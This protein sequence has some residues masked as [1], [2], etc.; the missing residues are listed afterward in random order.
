MSII[1]FSD[2]EVE[3]GKKVVIFPG[4]RKGVEGVVGHQGHVLALAVSSDGKY[5][6]RILVSV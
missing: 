2:R 3:S 1:I 6:V 4:H 5:L